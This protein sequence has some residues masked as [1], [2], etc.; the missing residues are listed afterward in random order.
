VNSLAFL[1]PFPLDL[2]WQHAKLDYAWLTQYEL[3]GQLRFLGAF[4]L[5]FAL[6]QW[7]FLHLRAAPADGPIGL[8]LV[9]QLAIGLPLIGIYP[10]AALDLF[11]YVLYGR[12][13]LYW[14][15]NPLAQRPSQ[16][17][18]E[19]MLGFSY[20]PDEPSVYGPL[21][22]L[23]SQWLTA[24]VEGQLPDGLYAFKLLALGSA[25]VTTFLIWLALRRLRPELA[26][27][28]ALFFGWNPLLQFET[29]GNGHN[30]ALMVAFLALACLVLVRGPRGLALPALSAGLLVKITLAPLVPLFALA[31]LLEQRR[32]R[33][34]IARLALAAL[35]SAVL[36]VGLYLPFWEGRASLPFLDRGNWF[37][38]SFPTLLREL[39]RRWQDYEQAGR[40]AALIS[41]SAFGLIA[42]VL[43]VRLARSAPRLSNLELAD[44]VLRTGYHLFFAYL[45]VAC[46][47]WQPW[48]LLVLLLFAALS[49]DR[50][51]AD[52]AS[53]FCLG[54][55][56][57]YPV[58]KY[59][60]A[61]HQVDWQLDYFKIMALSVAA[62]FTLPLAHLALTYL[63][64]AARRQSPIETDRAVVSSFD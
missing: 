30:D 10:V 39:F 1:R 5:L 45:V 11:D 16:F 57:S 47:W 3:A 60:W 4:L 52:R 21:W 51:L 35:L 14:G 18:N 42:L 58:F 27:A 8:I 46:L 6:F 7:A 33:A 37:T 28:G 55:L 50:S 26:P 49:G 53:L 63:V 34:R 62:I 61:I 56:L 59:V 31:P 64:R 41:G 29:A 40:S 36:I 19:P 23:V 2:W 44:Q 32:W 13:A 12:L 17:P 24:A 9:I 48:Y 20:W 22:Q 25:L 54:G 43:L 15:A 38:A